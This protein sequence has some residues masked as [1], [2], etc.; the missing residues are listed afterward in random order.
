MTRERLEIDGL[1][2]NSHRKDVF[3]PLAW[4]KVSWDQ[5]RK[6]INQSLN[7]LLE[8]YFNRFLP[9]KSV[10][11]KSSKFTSGFSSM[12]RAYCSI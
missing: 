6:K 9:T 12:K 5:P 11:D 7:S 4:E 3:D 10:K 2:E 1:A 8:R